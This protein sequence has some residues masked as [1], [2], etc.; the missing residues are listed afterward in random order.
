MEL[1]QSRVV[2]DDVAGMATF[3]ARLVGTS[4][5]PND[6]YVEV[7]PVAYRSGSRSAT[8]PRPSTSRPAIGRAVTS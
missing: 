7:R 4:V 8:S 5:I 1:V 6:Y 2:T 3:Y